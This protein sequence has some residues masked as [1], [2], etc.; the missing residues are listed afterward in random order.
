MQTGAIYKACGSGGEADAVVVCSSNRF[1]V[2]QQK[3]VVKMRTGG[4]IIDSQLGEILMSQ[5]ECKGPG[6]NPVVQTVT[7][8]HG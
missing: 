1:E 8:V 2:A 7:W 4:E 3:M 6:Y 5:E